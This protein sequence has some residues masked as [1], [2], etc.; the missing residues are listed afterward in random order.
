MESNSWITILLAWSKRENSTSR[1]L[2]SLAWGYVLFLILI[3][4]ALLGISLYLIE[5][6]NTLLWDPW[7]GTAI[8]MAA[9]PV[10]LLFLVWATITQWRIGQ[11]TPA[12]TAPTQKLIVSG[13][14]R[15]SRNPI[16][17][18]ATLFYLGLVSFAASPTSGISLFIICSFIGGCYH[19]FVEE[20]ELELRFGAD[21][22]A[23]KKNTP[24]I[25][26]KLWIR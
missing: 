23:Y 11:G 24:F 16:Q 15:R 2:A 4:A 19:A 13:P 9:I 7:I 5:P 8:A 14:Y 22:L 6:E 26:P 10:G 17:L 12:Y 3:P 20:R 21:Y 18:G 25:I 1:K